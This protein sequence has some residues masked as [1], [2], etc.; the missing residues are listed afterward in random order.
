M[1][2]EKKQIVQD[3][4][5]L[6]EQASTLFV[7]AYNG[8]DAESFAELRQALAAVG[9]ECHVV[10]N[11]LMKLALAESGRDQYADNVFRED[12]ALVT[13]TAEAV[14]VARTLRDFAKT[15]T[16]L[17]FKGGF[18]EGRACTAEEALSLAAMPP[19]EVLQAQLL[20][21]LLAPATGLARLL[22]AKVAQ[23]LYLL[24]AHKN[25]KQQ[26]T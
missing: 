8:L 12:S 6:L 10:P 18:V 9:G 7:V 3:L 1:R 13:T 21:L 15:H 16:A 23:I 17:S 2:P 19:R 14:T 20:G 26:A 11:R 22:N 25:K 5:G 4:C 24:N